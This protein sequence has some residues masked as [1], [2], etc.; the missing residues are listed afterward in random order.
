[1]QPKLAQAFMEFIISEQG[2]KLW[3]FRPGTPGGPQHTA[4]RRLPIRKDFYTQENRAFMSDPAEE[5]YEKA[6]ALVYHPEW[7]SPAFNSLRFIIRVLCVDTHDEL[8]HTWQMLNQ[9]GPS[10]CPRA[11]EVFHQLTLVDYDAAMGD[12]NKIISSNDKV[13]QVREA[14]RLT[15]AFRRQY[16][17]AYEFAKVQR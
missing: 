2:Q 3:D 6:K 16:E 9:Q 1:P 17:Q 11:V 8:V 5:P 12:I 4:L 14:R 7:T 15:D 10:R 13:L